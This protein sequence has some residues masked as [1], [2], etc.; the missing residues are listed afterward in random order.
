MMGGDSAVRGRLKRGKTAMGMSMMRAMVKMK[1][2]RGDFLFICSSLMKLT[3]GFLKYMG[4]RD[5][6]RREHGGAEMR[7]DFLCVRPSYPGCA[8]VCLGLWLSLRIRKRRRWSKDWTTRSF[9][10]NFTK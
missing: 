5:I 2:D 1:F 3:N 4:Q 7:R 10:T 6:R 9:K 8:W